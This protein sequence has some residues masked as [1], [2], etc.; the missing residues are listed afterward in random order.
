[1]LGD[2][3]RITTT[4]LRGQW[5][6]TLKPRLNVQHFTGNIFKYL[7]LKEHFTISYQI[8]FNL[9]QTFRF[10]APEENKGLERDGLHVSRLVSVNVAWLALTRKTEMLGEPVFSLAWCCQPHWMGHGQHP[11]IKWIWW[12]LWWWFEV[13]PWGSVAY[14]PF[15]AKLL[16]YQSQ[17]CLI[18]SKINLNE[19]SIIMLTI[20]VETICLTIFLATR[21][22]FFWLL[23]VHRLKLIPV[24]PVLCF[25]INA[26]KSCDA[27]I[28]GPNVHKS[29]CPKPVLAFGYS[30]FLHLC[31]RLE[32]NENEEILSY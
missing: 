3:F 31:V 21:L 30:C 17:C 9:S 22:M 6:N 28:W 1:M 15:G 5:V 13:L 10:P 11:N 29:F 20:I 14:H 16:L 32:R 25:N 27:C 18:V 24:A 26:L 4:T 8:P 19:I 12:W 2:Y 7:F 23:S